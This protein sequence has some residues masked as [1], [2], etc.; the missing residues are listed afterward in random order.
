MKHDAVDGMKD[1][2]RSG[3]PERQR[4]D[5]DAGEHWLPRQRARGESQI[6]DERVQTID[7]AAPPMRT[8]VETFHLGLDAA[9]VAESPP[10][11]ALGLIARHAARHELLDASG[12]VKL[13]L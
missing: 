9:V 12:D 13:Q 8:E 2:C 3:D 5:H 10:R 4:R 7:E 1:R 11:F 6:A